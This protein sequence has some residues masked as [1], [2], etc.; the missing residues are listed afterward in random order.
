[1]MLWVNELLDKLQS[2]EFDEEMIDLALRKGVIDMQEAAMMRAL[3]KQE[4][5]K[6]KNELSGSTQVKGHF[7]SGTTEEQAK[8]ESKKPWW[9]FW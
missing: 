5:K 9:K 3:L 2:S 1:M 4:N 8:E 7:S 6:R